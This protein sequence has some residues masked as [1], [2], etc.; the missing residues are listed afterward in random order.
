M[1]GK[2]PGRGRARTRTSE[3]SVERPQYPSA[4]SQQSTQQQQPAR[5]S[6]PTP[7]TRGSP[8][9]P[10]SPP[11]A[12]VQEVAGR[13]R[14]REAPERKPGE[15]SSPS[16]AGEESPPTQT[17][18]AGRAALRGKQVT[19]VSGTTT[20]LVGEMAKLELEEREGKKKTREYRPEPV[21]R[22]RMPGMN[23]KEDLMG[24]SGVEVKVFANYFMID[25][26]LHTVFQHYHVDFDPPVERKKYRIELV[27]EHDHM[28]PNNKAF[29]GM[30]L[31]SVDK[32][33]NDVIILTL[34]N[35]NIFIHFYF[36]ISQ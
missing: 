35:L 3:R 8:P 19:V 16:E 20:G 31:Y 7:P 1:S 22:L 2:T 17:F 11:S 33:A 12:A 13:G 30:N 15:I 29:D 32:L 10:P 5:V 21:P 25:T 24:T 4:A 6:P 9:T 28:F 14:G 26:K 36:K 18:T 34:L 23:R 27:K